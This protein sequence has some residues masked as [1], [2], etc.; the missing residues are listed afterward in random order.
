MLNNAWPS[1]IW[2]LYD[3]YL[4]PGGAYFATK[5]AC[6]PLHVLYR[7]DNQRSWSPTIRSIRFQLDRDR[8]YLRPR[9]Q[10]EHHE[11][12]TCSA[13]ANA[14]RPFSRYRSSIKFRQRIFRAGNSAATPR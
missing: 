7:Y 6:E 1:M 5:V 2:H 14:V 3:Y 11:Q 9:Q 10:A 4:R 8:G 13:M 12:G